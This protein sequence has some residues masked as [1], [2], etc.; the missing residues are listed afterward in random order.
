MPYANLEELES[1]LSTALEIVGDGVKIKDERALRGELID[2]L[3]RSAVFGDEQVRAAARWAIWAAS[4]ACGCVSASIQGLYEAMGRGEVSG[5]TVPAINIRGLTYDVAR[6]VFRAAGALGTGPLLFE[7]ARS[8]IGYTEQRPAEYASS[9]LAAAIK[10]SWSLP[11]LL[12]G[13]HF[14][15][16]LKKF[17][18]DADAELGAVKDLVREA[19]A[20]G[21]FNIDVDTSTLVDL[22]QPTLDEQ[23]R[24]NYE[25]CAEI[26]AVIRK[27]EPEGIAISVGG[28]IG[29]VGGKNSTVEELRAFM[30][31]LRRTAPELKGISK[32]SV[33]TGTSHGG[34]PLPDGTIAKVALDFGVLEAIGK[35][36]REEY[37]ISGAVQHGAST[38]PDEAFHRFPECGTSE[39]HLATGFQN[40]IYDHERFPAEL[41]DEV[42][43]HLHGA[44]AGERKQG[45]T[46]EQFLYKTRKK[47]FGPFKRQM[48]DLPADVR[49]AIAETLH[50]KFSFLFEK[51][52]TRGSVGTLEAHVVPIPVT[53]RKPEGL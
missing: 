31:G 26:T 9:V 41:R 53:H 13:D 22:D 39:I 43:A 32:I 16:N 49:A 23:Q 25:R 10:E 48:W 20:A 6:T 5:L 15:V 46:D 18:A 8:E 4:Q 51:L 19:I 52:G 30:D 1:A 34:I 42:Y 40:I 27:H 7:I 44:H 12:Q 33:Q 37:G 24:N 47:G 3:A 28:E 45:Q 29:E 21:F 2:R 38:L 36:A 11:V 50:A 35:V 14:Q 17:T